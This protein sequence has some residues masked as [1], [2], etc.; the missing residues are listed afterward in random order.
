MLISA[1]QSIGRNLINYFRYSVYLIVFIGFHSSLAGSYDDFFVAIKRD[2]PAAMRDLLAR[3][4]DPN[5]LSP[6][7][8][9]GLMLAVREPSLKVASVLV[10]AKQTQV[11]HR[12]KSG[13]SP[14]MMASIKGYL[15]LAQQLIER[16]ADVNKTGWTPLHYAASGGQVAVINLLLEHHAYIDASSPNGST[17]LMMAALYGSP[18]AVKTLLEAGADPTIK[19]DLGLTAID[20]AHRDNRVESAEIIAAFIR[21]RAPKGKW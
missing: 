3:G 20:F 2:N 5:T 21:G 17:P 6:N 11:E 12:N 14:L 4:F 7:G 19:N 13:E 8:E 16:G 10:A 15:D 9:H 18:G 1:V